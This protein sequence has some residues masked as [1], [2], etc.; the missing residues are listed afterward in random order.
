MAKSLSSWSGEG[1]MMLKLMQ[2]S[3]LFDE[4]KDDYSAAACNFVSS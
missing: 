1:S 4:A 2:I 3:P